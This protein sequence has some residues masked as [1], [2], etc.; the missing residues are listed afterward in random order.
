MKKKPLIITTSIIST[1]LIAFIGYGVWKNAKDTFPLEEDVYNDIIDLGYE[2]VYVAIEDDEILIRF[3]ILELNS[4]LLAH[5]MDLAIIAAEY[6]PDVEIIIVQSYFL[7]EAF[8]G[9]TADTD[10]VSDYINETIT[11]E[12]LYDKVTF[13][14]L[15]S[16]IMKL[17]TDLS[18]FSATVENVDVD[19][20]T[21]ELVLTYDGSSEEEFW[22]DYTAMILVILEDC[23]WVEQ[24]TMTYNPIE[25]TDEQ[26]I[27]TAKTENILA[28]IDESMTPEDFIN[29]LLIAQSNVINNTTPETTNNTNTNA[30]NTTTE[31]GDETYLAAI[32]NYYD[33][34]LLEDYQDASAYLSSNLSGDWDDATGGDAVI[35]SYD[36]LYYEEKNS[37]VTVSIEELLVGYDGSSA[38]NYIDYVLIQENDTWLIDEITEKDKIFLDD[39]TAVSETDAIDTVGRFLNAL[40]NNNEDEAKTYATDTF[41][42]SE[43]PGLFSEYT[44]FDEL[45]IA[46]TKAT[47]TGMWVY[48]NET[49]DGGKTDSRYLVID[50]DNSLFVHKRELI[51]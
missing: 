23:P 50:Q 51:N 12:K 41:I 48:V 11:N 21:A 38:L 17:S 33:A 16:I 35:T 2:D 26:L 30:T 18:I 49:W 28:F 39:T 7:H 3:E 6:E 22:S 9:L 1:L 43:T 34:L 45:E 32:N 19:D 47:D 15:R 4:E 20:D 44:L 14:D 36:I 25:D 24:I 31:T 40:K 13:E 37:T 42:Q 10:V 27:I 29:S 46:T 5:M 8:F